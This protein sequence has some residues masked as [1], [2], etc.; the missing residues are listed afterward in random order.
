MTRPCKVGTLANSQGVKAP[1]G[2]TCN[3]LGQRPRVQKY[4]Y[5]KALKARNYKT[6]SNYYPE[7][8]RAPSA[9]TTSVAF[10][11]GRLAQAFAC[12]AFGA[13]LAGSQ[14]KWSRGS[15]LY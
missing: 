9:L 3:S 7:L 5:Y 15:G 2:A 13:Q 12:R 11:L 6:S 4:S 8:N 10:D 14:I 1:K